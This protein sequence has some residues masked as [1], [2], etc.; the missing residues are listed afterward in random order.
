MCHQRFSQLL[1]VAVCVTALACT[2]QTSHA[3]FISLDP[4][5]SGSPVILADLLSGQVM[6]VTVGDKSFSEFF[7]STLPGDDMPAPEDINVFG[8]Q[9]DDGN[10][11]VS[12]HGAFID[13]PGNGP[14][15]A[16]LRFTVEVT[17][18][19]QAQGFRIS[20]AHLF[21]GGVGVGENSVF[22]IDET[23]Q[24][25]DATLNAFAT[26]LGGPLETQLS[27]WVFFDEDPINEVYTRLRVTKDIFALAGD[28]NQPARTTVIDQSFSQVQ[29]PEPT[30][31]GLLGL[32]LLGVALGRREF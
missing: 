15:D 9:D 26:T 31:L 30:T 5:G 20:D 12:F 6:G 17:P 18:E 27:D 11:G 28:T 3:S 7:Y 16:L 23:F 32:A 22:T 13:L 10:Y 29:I 19:A 1:A 24:Q 4:N 8:F 21:A 2:T 25:N 14:S